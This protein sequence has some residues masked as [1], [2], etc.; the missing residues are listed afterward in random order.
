MLKKMFAEILN[1]YGFVITE[2]HGDYL[3]FIKNKKEGYI[4]WNNTMAFMSWR[5]LNIFI[6]LTP[7]DIKKWIVELAEY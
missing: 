2:T 5:E 4:E 7:D 6:S 3:K 1:D